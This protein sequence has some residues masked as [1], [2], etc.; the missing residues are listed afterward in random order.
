VSLANELAHVPDVDTQRYKGTNTFLTGR[1]RVAQLQRI[2]S[3]SKPERG[4]SQ[5]ALE[6]VKHITESE[7]IN[8]EKAGTKSQP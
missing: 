2:E 1:R 3:M 8:G 4:E 7:P 5:K 6:Q